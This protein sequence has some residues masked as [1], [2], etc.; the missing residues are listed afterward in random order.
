MSNLNNYHAKSHEKEQGK[1]T[2]KCVL[3]YGK[4]IISG[5]VK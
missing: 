4:N 5:I 3:W 2:S 1:I